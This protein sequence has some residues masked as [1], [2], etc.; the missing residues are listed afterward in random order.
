V[1]KPVVSLAALSRDGLEDPHF[2]LATL[3]EDE[4]LMISTR[5]GDE[6]VEWEPAN[7]DREFRGAV[8]LR[9]ALEDSLNVPMARLGQQVGLPRIIQIARGLGIESRLAAV[10]SLA[11]GSFEVTLLEMTR[12]YAVLAAGGRRAAPVTTLAVLRQG[13]PVLEPAGRE[14]QGV[15]DPAE[16]YLVTS[17]LQGAVERGTGQSLR[18]WGYRGAVAGKTG[19]TN[20]YR[21]AW[22]I[23]YTPEIVVGVWVGFDDG[24]SLG[25]T[26]ARAAL[27]IFADFLIRALGR[28][29]RGDFV[30]PP[31]VDRVRI[32]AREG[33][34]A[35][36]RCRGGAE[37]FLAGTAPTERCRSFLGRLGRWFGRIGGG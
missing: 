37:V 22:F 20:D 26:G 36:L 33:H 24:H 13:D 2:T 5:E 15:F 32:V 4:P 19:T 23:G 8:T 28:D 21:D 3:L 16:V 6:E 11:L 7:H 30:P 25:M 9:R 27:P 17:A 10:P 14:T 29:G 18:A 34:P 1:F 31:G 12:A 35:G